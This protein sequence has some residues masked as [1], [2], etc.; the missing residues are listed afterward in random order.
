[1]L[2]N[3]WKITNEQVVKVFETLLVIVS[4]L[5]FFASFIPVS[6][7]L[8]V[9]PRW[10]YA[11]QWRKLWGQD[12]QDHVWTWLPGLGLSEPTCPR[13]HSFQV[14]LP[15]SEIGCL[16]LCNAMGNSILSRFFSIP[17]KVNTPNV[18]EFQS[19][20]FPTWLQKKYTFFFKI[21]LFI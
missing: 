19:L 9:L 17:Q 7:F 3:W 14:S 20:H 11:L 5:P 13:I 1:M 15:G 6:F 18:F 4:S 2:G 12:C 16:S 21:Y 8:S 10:M